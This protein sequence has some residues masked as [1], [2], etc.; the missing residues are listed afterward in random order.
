MITVATI[1]ASIMHLK[2]NQ[3]EKGV[4]KDFNWLAPRWPSPDS[5]PQW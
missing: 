3:R 4:R 5:D 2:R 1:A